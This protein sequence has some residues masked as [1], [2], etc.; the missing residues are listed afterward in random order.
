MGFVGVRAKS[1]LRFQ[2]YKYKIY[3]SGETQQKVV[4]HYYS[5]IYLIN[6]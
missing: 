6:S 5:R 3:F 4:I 2:S 1:T